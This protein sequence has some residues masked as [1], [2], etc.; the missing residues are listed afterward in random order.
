MPF[1]VSRGQRIH[2][3]DDGAG[4][5]VVLQHGLLLDAGSWRQAGIVSALAQ[6]YRVLCVDSLGHGLSDKPT[7][8]EFYDQKQRA[9]DIAAVLDDVGAEHANYIGHSMGGWLGVGMAKFQPHRLTSLAIGGWDLVAG[10]PATSRGPL[11]YDAFMKFVRR[12]MPHL[13]NWITPDC[14]PGLAACFHALGQLEGARESVL[15]LRVPVAIWSGVDDPCHA[16]ASAFARENDLIFLS[17]PGDH[18]GPIL[19]HGPD[20]ARS[21]TRFLDRID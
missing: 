4:T 21:L 10:L 14:E 9:A 16:P 20:T 1:V 8:P 19:A 11:T 15:N 17:V 7:H 13:L 12:S 3:T 6:R 18:L 5:A 2:Y